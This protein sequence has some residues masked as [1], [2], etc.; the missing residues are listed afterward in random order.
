MTDWSCLQ[1]GPRTGRKRL[2]RLGAALLTAFLLP[3]A[4]R[5]DRSS[6][7]MD[8]A[9][10]YEK[11]GKFAEAALYYHR[12]LRGLREMYFAFHWNGDPKANAASKRHGE[13]YT[14]IPVEME[15]RFKKCSERA[16]LKPDEI[17]RMERVTRGGVNRICLDH[18]QRGNA[19]GQG[20]AVQLFAAVDGHLAQHILDA[21]LFP[22]DDVDNGI[23]GSSQDIQFIDAV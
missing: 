6:T 19:V 3:S 14:Q 23:F 16:Q 10:M 13:E 15:D 9:W 17:K 5:A 22:R 7:N 1:A 8:P 4:S 12:T 20:P 11:K 2:F 21:S 18:I